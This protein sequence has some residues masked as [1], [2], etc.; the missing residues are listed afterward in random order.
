MRNNPLFSLATLVLFT[1]FACSNDKSEMIHAKPIEDVPYYTIDAKKLAQTVTITRDNYGI[2]HIT[3]PTDESVLFGLAYARAEDHFHVIEDAVISATGR[4]AEVNGES[5]VLA[6]YGVHAFRVC[7][8][9]REEYAA[10]PNK[11]KL[12]CDAYAEG[13][14]YYLKTHPEVKP[15]L[16]TRFEP[17]EF[18]AVERNM[19][20]S[21][22]LSMSGFKEDGFSKYVNDNR[23]EP[24]VGSNM[25]AISPVRSK[26]GKTYLVIN[27]HIPADQPYE[28]HL[29]SEEG[30]NFYGMMAY[31]MN[32]IPPVGHNDSLGWSLTVNYPDVGDAF[33]MRFDDPDDSLK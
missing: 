24:Q 25:W 13:L 29:K 31:G 10:F 4:Q 21:F 22:G 28:V 6:D 14:N 27:P 16:I 2:P 26:N 18:L 9:S 32:L 30:L 17:W 33:Q 5:S 8:L 20:G 15:K 7:E 23:R 11:I 19:W 3:G 12:L 1:A